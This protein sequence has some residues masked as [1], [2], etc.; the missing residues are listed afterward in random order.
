MKLSINQPSYIPWLGYFERIAISDKHVVL[1]HVQFEKNSMVNRNKILLSGR[2]VM[3]TIP[4]KTK[5]KFGNLA[6]N[7][8]EIDISQ[9]WK[10][11]HLATISQ[12]YSKSPFF[13]D[14]FPNIEKFYAS[15]NEDDLL[16]EVLKK[17]I[18]M[19]IEYLGIDTEIIFSSD[20]G[21]HGKKSD[22]ILDICKMVEANSYL[23]GPFGRDYLDL[24]AFDEA[25]INVDFHDY[26]HPVYSQKTKEFH[27]NLSV[28]DLIFNHGSESK[29]ILMGCN[30]EQGAN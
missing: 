1:D 24:S 21:S 15:I 27:P 30:C 25:G 2:E 26:N 13:H 8:V 20:L 10:K 12:S 18:R 9:N 23:S 7:D 22:L 17:N 14:F 29:C 3:L 6:I 11:K 5:G 28:I 19:F 16:G 4:L